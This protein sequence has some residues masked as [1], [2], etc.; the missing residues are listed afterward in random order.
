MALSRGALVIVTTIA[1]VVG[2]SY[3]LDAP[4]WF[5]SA[6]PP[7]PSGSSDDQRTAAEPNR[8]TTPAKPPGQVRPQ[9]AGPAQEALI[10]SKIRPAPAASEAAEASATDDPS[11]ATLA[12]P[13]SAT[14]VDEPDLPRARQAVPAARAE[15][16]PGHTASSITGPAEAEGGGRTVARVERDAEPSSS[17]R[18]SGQPQDG[19][20]EPA[21]PVSVAR[22]TPPLAPPAPLACSAT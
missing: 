16:S 10:R 12:E 22:A 6:R 11:P 9:P 19:A 4:S 7:A 17:G 1:V 20:A 13:R 18:T 3:A 5:D 21:P 8:A 2:L 15:A 14:V